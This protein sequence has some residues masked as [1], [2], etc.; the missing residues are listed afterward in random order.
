MATHSSVL[1]W[2]IPGMEEPSGLPSMG[3][4]RVGQDWS[5]LAIAAAV[6]YL[7]SL[8][9]FK[10]HLYILIAVQIL[11]S[12]LFNACFLL[13]YEGFNSYFIFFFFKKFYWRIVALQCFVSFY[14]TTSS[15]IHSPLLLIS[16]P[17]RYYIALSRVP[18]ATLVIYFIHSIYC[19]Y[20]SIPVSQFIPSS[21]FIFEL[22]SLHKIKYYFYQA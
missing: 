2:R 7:K 6:H 1:A 19:V 10:L 4:H 13:L 15:H 16:F 11:M 22:L 3:S 17:F 12:C 8:N 20:V 14:C 5:D 9:Q 21:M 18:C